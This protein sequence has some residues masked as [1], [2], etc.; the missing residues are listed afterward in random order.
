[1]IPLRFFRDKTHVYVNNPSGIT[2]KMTIAEFEQM[3]S[4]SGGGSDIPEHSSSNQG[5]VLSVDADGDLVWKALPPAGGGLDYVGFLTLQNKNTSSIA[6]GAAR[7][8]PINDIKDIYD[9]DGNTTTVIPDF[10]LAI[11]VGFYA[12]DQNFNGTF[13]GYQSSIGPADAPLFEYAP[14]MRISNST[15]NSL[16][17]ADGTLEMSYCLYKLG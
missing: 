2:K 11:F 4:G 7:D 8:C 9:I 16:A 6:N 3:M 17:V 12:G 14:T 15:G 5:E 1:M 10:D 13:K